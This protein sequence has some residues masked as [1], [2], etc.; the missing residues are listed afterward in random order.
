MSGDDEQFERPSKSARKRESESLQELG[1][2]LIDMP[3]TLFDALP[4]PET[5][6]D[7]VLAARRFTSHGAQVR[8]RQYIGKLMRKF[9]VAPVRAAIEQQ[10]EARRADARRFKRIESWRDRLIREGEGALME[11][12]ATHPQA[13]ASEL[14]R[15]VSEA[16]VQAEQKRPP[17]AARQL[18][19]QL[20][21]ALESRSD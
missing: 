10:Q 21:V 4:L 19:E 9:D 1:E 12:C 20:R 6:R 13:N 5:L 17:R 8:Q 7:A 2:A 14:R 15:L 18:F 11:F 3:D 16:H